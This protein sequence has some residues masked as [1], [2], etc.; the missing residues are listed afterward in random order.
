MSG[1]LQVMRGM[2]KIFGIFL[3]FFM[4]LSNTTIEAI[5]IEDDCVKTIEN[6]FEVTIDKNTAINLYDANDDIVAFYYKIL[7][8]GYIIIESKT[9]GV[10]EYS[11]TENNKYIEN[12][13]KI[14]YYSG[15]LGYFETIS[16]LDD[17]VL[18]CRTKERI[19]KN[20]VKFE[21]KVSLQTTIN[22]Q[23]SMLDSEFVLSSDAISTTAVTALP[24]LTQPYDTN[25]GGIC[26]ATASAILLEYYYS[27]IDSSVTPA[28]TITSDGQLL[29]NTL[30][31]YIPANSNF[32][33]LDEGLDL[34][35]SNFARSSKTADRV[36]FLNILMKPTTRMEL[37][38][39]NS[40]PSIVGLTQH[41]TYGEHWVVATGYQKNVQYVTIN[42]GWG[43]RGI[44]IPYSYIDSCIFLK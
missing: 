15:P 14:Y 10:V 16:T 12:N 20:K 31:N 6:V 29:T 9:F 36:T 23:N 44:M 25:V 4:L 21:N 2:F 26:G 5:A 24:Y 32:L 11:I 7:P 8:I 34:Y 28:I 18:D 39:M 3:V 19:E 33:Q 27:H 42:D 13:D 40:E 38:I 1:D 43:S 41:P 30:V 22:H 37:S 17:Y 35:L